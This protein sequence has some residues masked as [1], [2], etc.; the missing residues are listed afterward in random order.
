MNISFVN[1]VKER[2]QLHSI[3]QMRD[4]INRVI[5]VYGKSGIGKTA[6][7]NNVL[8]QISN[9]HIYNVRIN[10][11]SEYADGYFYRELA[12]SISIKK[13]KDL[14]LTA[15]VTELKSIV[16]NKQAIRKG[17][18]SLKSSIVDM[19]PGIAIKFIN[20]L[21]DAS[22]EIS[23]FD[24][25]KILNSYDI[26]AFSLIN[27]YVQYIFN[28]ESNIVHFENIQDIDYV[29]LKA[30]IELV[31]QPN[32]STFIFEY[33][34][35]LNGHYSLAELIDNIVITGAKVITMPIGP[36]SHNDIVKIIDQFPNAQ[37]S[38]ITGNLMIDPENLRTLI[39]YLY[40]V[41]Y[42]PYSIE[43]PQ[44]HD[45]TKM[46]LNHLSTNERFILAMIFNHIEPVPHSIFDEATLLYHNYNHTIYC[47]ELL[48]SSLQSLIDKGFIYE[49]PHRGFV[50]THDYIS[51]SII[52]SSMWDH[53]HLITQQFWYSYYS[54]SQQISSVSKS[55]SLC[56]QLFYAACLKKYAIVL[57]LLDSLYYEATKMI[58]P[59]N[60]LETIT[61]L[62]KSLPK[63]SS[64]LD[65]IDMWLITLHCSLSNYKQAYDIICSS[66][67]SG[68]KYTLMKII[69][70]EELG[71]KQDALTICEEEIKS[72]QD[73][74]CGYFIALRS[75]RIMLNYILGNYN[76]VVT[77]YQDCL[78]N[79]SYTSQVEYGYV[80]RNAEL[81]YSDSCYEASLAPIWDSVLHFKDKGATKMEAYSRLTFGV[82]SALAGRLKKAEKQFEIAQR[83]LRDDV[84]ERHSIFNNI[85]V[86]RMFQSLYDEETK[87]ALLQALLTVK[88]GY[89]DYTAIHVNLL[90]LLDWR[91][92]DDDALQIIPKLIEAIE[93]RTYYN[94]EIVAS[95]YYN[96]AQF[97][98]KIGNINLYSEYISKTIEFISDDDLLWQYRLYGNPLPHNHNNRIDASVNRA[99]SFISN[100]HIDFDLKYMQYE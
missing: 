62:K 71:Y 93:T 40:M 47:G 24:E 2:G 25:N 11:S 45:F 58:S 95:A 22:S 68:P 44:Q 52:N 55:T 6:L 73:K 75:T 88:E 66:N 5:Y 49:D 27:E 10:H 78:N 84:T 79:S 59:D 32:N 72:T 82:Q 100:W 41:M 46:S 51:T 98:K 28:H 7:V 56:K 92:E 80:L 15:F 86:V 9:E 3:L 13:V 12:K 4:P 33:T 61:V 96:I 74:S 20:A 81:V 94:V 31:K 42:N 14:N 64:V 53:L 21:F 99:L 36:L 57:H 1:R 29:S 39:D 43:G 69:V 30:L 8:G 54:N 90:A 38:V 76:K 65:K 48:K 18:D 37:K 83:L 91:N 89:F 63:N 50:I 70:L 60:L 17:V 19:A 97:Y 35:N 87:W 34:S 67:C 16:A 85:A 23:S 77:E 26:G